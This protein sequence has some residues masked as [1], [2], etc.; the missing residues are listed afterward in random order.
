MT[1]T[2]LIMYFMNKMQSCYA[3]KKLMNMHRRNQASGE[4]Y[5]DSPSRGSEVISIQAAEPRSAEMFTPFASPCIRL[6]STILPYK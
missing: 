1:F 6:G 4:P 3:D 2:K 5:V